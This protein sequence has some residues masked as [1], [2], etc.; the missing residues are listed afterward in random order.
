MKK[1]TKRLIFYMAMV[2]LPV[3]QF[4]IFYIF[5]NLNSIILAFKSI[6]KE[7]GPDGLLR[8]NETFIGF[9]NFKTVFKDLFDGEKV[10]SDVWKNTFIAYFVGVA[11]MPLSLLFSYYIFKKFFGASIFKVVL[12][13]PQVVS[14]LVLIIMYRYF[15]V[16]VLPVLF[17]GIPDLL[18]SSS[19]NAFWTL[20]VFGIWM[21]FGSSVMMYLGGMNNISESIMEYA[22]LDGATAL[23]EFIHI[24]FPMV[25]PTV[26]TFVVVGMAGI[27]TNQMRLFDFYGTTAEPYLQ[28]LGYYMYAGVKRAGQDLTKYP[29]FATMGIVFTLITVPL[30]LTTRWVMQKFGPGV[31]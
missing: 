23:K 3:L 13:L 12:F 10:V 11:T 7:I 30:T 17:P 9:E 21:G 16:D 24:I 29:Y 14:G 25:Y 28:T 20:L 1:K 2:S 27:F 19:K 8:Y 31:D 15:V 26:A 5:V 4:V 6:T 22:K 18:D